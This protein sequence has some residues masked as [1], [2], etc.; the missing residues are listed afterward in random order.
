MAG[1]TW[2]QILRLTTFGESHGPAVGGVL[3]GVP[4]GTLLDL[5]AVQSA[6][7]R[8]KTG[9]NPYASSRQESDLVEWLSGLE[10][11]APGQ[12]VRALGT[13]IAFLVRNT[14]AHSSDYDALQDVFRPSHADYTWWVKF[15]LRDARGGGRASARET[16]ARVVAGD[17]AIKSHRLGAI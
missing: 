5:E 6:V 2:G 12:P 16:V 4:G 7:N 17:N 8:R 10:P 13:P 14:N 1:N 15:G 9:Q 11:G 3:D